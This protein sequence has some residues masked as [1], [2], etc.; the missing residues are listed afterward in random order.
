MQIGDCYRQVKAIKKYVLTP[1][2]NLKFASSITASQYLGGH[3]FNNCPWPKTIL[4]YLLTWI[5]T[6]N[7]SSATI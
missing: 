6:H 4:D 5:I 3:L 7:N 2:E 1:A